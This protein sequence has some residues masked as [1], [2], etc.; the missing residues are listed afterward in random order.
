[1][2]TKSVK[3]KEGEKLDD[4]NLAKV[5]ALLEQE[6]PITKKLA[7]EYLNISYN[8]TRLASIIEKFKAKIEAEKAQRAAKRG[9]PATPAEIQ[10]T[11]ESY[12]EG[13]T[14]DAISSSLFRSAAFINKIL[15]DNNVPKRSRSSSYFTPELIPDAA[16]AE[17]FE[18]G[19]TVYS[20]R[21]D[22]TAKIE[23]SVLSDNTEENVYRIWLLSP[24]WLQYAYQPA[25]ELASL[26]HL[27][28][29]GINV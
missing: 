23:A 22:S 27:K 20:V 24:K 15:E 2:A 18:E 8:T 3:V 26:A 10:F 19:E 12:L 16:V 28:K 6:T 29:I 4:A 7:C 13:R 1:M 5:I 11:V 9:K 21:Y 14:V 17:S 25:S